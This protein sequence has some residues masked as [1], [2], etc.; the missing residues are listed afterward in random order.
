M[1]SIGKQLFEI[2]NFIDMSDKRKDIDHLLFVQQLKEMWIV[3]DSNKYNER[4]SKI[5]IVRI[6][7]ELVRLNISEEVETWLCE[8][9]IITPQSPQYAMDFL[10]GKVYYQLK[11]YDKASE[12]LNKAYE[13]NRDFFYKQ[14]ENF[15]KFINK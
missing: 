13:E 14:G 10:R 2:L 11:E 7:N 5:I 9:D 4:N 3:T 1:N 6:I 15:I 12:Y 8:L